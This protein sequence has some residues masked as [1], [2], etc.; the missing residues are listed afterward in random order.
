V[1]LTL[2]RTVV[3]LRLLEQREQRQR[4]DLRTLDRGGEDE[5]LDRDARVA[6]AAA[7]GGGRWPRF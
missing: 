3:A 5:R 1:R 4:R 7:T 6:A 2:L